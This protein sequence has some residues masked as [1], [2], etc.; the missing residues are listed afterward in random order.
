MLTRRLPI[1][2]RVPNN[3]FSNTNDVTKTA[4]ASTKAWYYDGA[5][6]EFKANDA[7]TTN[8]IAHDSL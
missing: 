3:P 4:A 1:L 6:G 7:G 8:G 2:P 5:T